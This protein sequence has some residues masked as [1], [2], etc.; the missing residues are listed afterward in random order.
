MA[1]EKSSARRRVPGARKIAMAAVGIG[2][3]VAGVWWVFHDVDGDELVASAGRIRPLWLLGSIAVYWLGLVLLRAVLVR[4]L[5]APVGALRLS[6]AYRYICIGFLA[7][8]VLPL[9]AGEVARSAALA[10]GA[11]VS[12]TSVVGSLA[13]E[14]MLDLAMVAL[15]GLAAIQVAPLPEAVRTAALASGG[16]LVVGFALL[17]VFARR[18][19]ARGD[20]APAAKAEAG[21]PLW[22]GILGIWDRFSAGFGAF[23]TGRGIALSGAMAA[24]IWTLALAT[25]LL[26][27]AAFDLEPSLPIVLVLLASLGFGVAVPSAPGYVGTYHAAAV[28]ALELFGVDHDTAAAYGLFSWIVD[29]GLSSLAGAVSL[30]VEGV[31]LADLRARSGAGG[32][33]RR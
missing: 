20:A 11:R 14:R 24:G 10:R 1:E 9:R 12:F 16:A 8:N 19:R 33:D 18:R 23:G 21:R 5:V 7:N 22:T 13:V 2:L 30:S 4:H 29:I 6:Q 27:L 3:S 28:F 25:M 26:R 17:A 32:A 15:I 31:A